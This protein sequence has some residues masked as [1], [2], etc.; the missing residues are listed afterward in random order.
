MRLAKSV[1]EY[2]RDLV[3][4][5]GELGMGSERNWRC[6]RT[7]TD[8]LGDVNVLFPSSFIKW[9][10]CCV[11]VCSE[12]EWMKN[13]LT[14]VTFDGNIRSEKRCRSWDVRCLILSSSMRS[15]C[16]F[17]MPIGSASARDRLFLRYEGKSLKW[18][19]VVVRPSKFS[20]NFFCRNCGRRDTYLLSLHASSYQ[21]PSSA[22]AFT[23][24]LR[25][26]PACR[27]RRDSCT[28]S[29]P[30]SF[31]AFTREPN[32]FMQKS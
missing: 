1:L 15:F 4:I 25:L 8:N 19:K 3:W 23:H 10:L 28:Q 13:G 32:Q 9:T 7:E 29:S 17:G 5:G 18:W 24:V 20:P 27:V 26:W 31:F 2:E 6:D 11:R 22:I 14:P 12:C 30:V 16:Y 21:E